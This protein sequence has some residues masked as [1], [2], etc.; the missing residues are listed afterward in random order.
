MRLRQEWCDRDPANPAAWFGIGKLAYSLG[1]PEEAATALK[2]VVALAPERAEGHALLAR[3]E[4]VRKEQ[5]SLIEAAATGGELARTEA[6]RHDSAWTWTQPM[7][8]E[9]PVSV[10]D[11]E[12]AA[13]PA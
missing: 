9:L 13:P 6:A 1:L 3:A 4:S 2:N 7:L 11:A 10:A 5:M 12:P 8:G